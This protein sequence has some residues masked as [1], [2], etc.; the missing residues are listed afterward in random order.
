MVV[1]IAIIPFLGESLFPEFKERDF[2]SH[3]ITKPGTSV[4]EERRVVTQISNEVRA[5]PGVRN[6]GTHIG[7]ALLAD[8]VCGVNFGENWLSIDP[9]ADY[10]ET[11][12][13]IKE[14]VYAHPGIFRNVETYL[15]ER[16]DEVLTG[17]S[18]T[19]VVRIFGPEFE[20][21]ST[22]RPTKCRRP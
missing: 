10:D 1:G 12:D 22:Q 3:C 17:T 16:I 2:L 20:R 19:F 13:K 18:E 5:I 6:F 9:D 11:L 4:A 14:V 15:N 8:E 7:M 21:D